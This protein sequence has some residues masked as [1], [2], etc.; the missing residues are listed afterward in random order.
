MSPRASRRSAWCSCGSPRAAG[1]RR[2]CRSAC[3]G[4]RG[5]ASD[6]PS[7]TP[8]SDSPS[9]ALLDGRGLPFGRP[10]NT[11]LDRHACGHEAEHLLVQP[12]LALELLDG[13]RLGQALDDGV[14]ALA[15]LA[16]VVGETAL[17]P[18]L[19]LTH[20]GAKSLQVLPEP[21]QKRSDLLVGG[22]RIDDHQDLV[23]IQT[24]HLPQ[25]QS[26]VRKVLDD[27]RSSTGTQLQRRSSRRLRGSVKTWTKRHGPCRL[28]G[29]GRA[30][31]KP[32]T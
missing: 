28:P 1:P 14:G 18:A 7:E 12:K 9:G 26:D 29:R 22:P 30:P 17:A 23:R 4:A 32:R 25:L 20:F 27:T 8:C 19:D 3:N 13:G 5:R 15:L 11:L 2:Q 6:S 16:Q 24:A 10:A 31:R 21:G